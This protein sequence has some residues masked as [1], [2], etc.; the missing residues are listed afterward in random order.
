MNRNDWDETTIELFRQ[1][2][3]E[4]MHR[5]GRSISTTLGWADN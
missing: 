2:L 4:V 1:Y 5:E 3:E